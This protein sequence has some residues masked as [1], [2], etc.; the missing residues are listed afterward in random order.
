MHELKPYAP[1]R[2]SQLPFIAFTK[3]FTPE[4]QPASEEH[5][6]YHAV[7]LVAQHGTPLYVI[8]EQRLRGDFRKFRSTFTMA[9]RSISPCQKATRVTIIS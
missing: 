6:E 5:S 9:S 2:I 1:P 8:S 7:Q 3:H 4:L